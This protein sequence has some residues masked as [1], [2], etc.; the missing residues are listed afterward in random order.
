MLKITYL[1][2][3]HRYPKQLRRLIQRLHTEHAAFLIHID[4]RVDIALFQQE[5]RDVNFV[6]FV[7]N[8]HTSKWGSRGITDAFLS[9]FC[10]ILSS[11]FKT[12]YVIVLS[13]QDYPLRSNEQIQQFFTRPVNLGKNFVYYFPMPGVSEY[14]GE[15][16]D[17]RGG[18]R[19]SD[20]MISGSLA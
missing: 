2:L 4:S 6:R 14:R 5:L 9:G 20:S 16:N 18:P 12:D 11:D 19:N 13:G 15:W 1:I 17:R 10:E 3:A 7:V 8:R